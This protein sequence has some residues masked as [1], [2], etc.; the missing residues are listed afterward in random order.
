M[1]DLLNL[2]NEEFLSYAQGYIPGS[3]AA[4]RIERLRLV[5]LAYIASMENSIKAFYLSEGYEVRTYKREHE[6]YVCKLVIFK[7]GNYMIEILHKQQHH[8]KDHIIPKLLNF[9]FGYVY[10]VKSEFGYKIGKSKELNKRIRAFAVELPFKTECKYYFRTH[11]MRTDENMTHDYFAEH[12]LNGEW[13][14][15]TD[16]QISEYCK[17]RGIKL[18]GY[19][20]DH[21]KPIVM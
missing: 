1:N 15:I 9:E 7:S 2:I 12:R 6:H 4:D 8:V 19:V 3:K 16:S 18:S 5:F 20:K 14:N 17:G 11:N 10:F 13:F 21:I